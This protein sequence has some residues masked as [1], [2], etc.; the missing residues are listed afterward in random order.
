MARETSPMI[1]SLSVENMVREM[2]CRVTDSM[3]SERSISAPSGKRSQ[4]WA[5]KAWAASAMAG[6]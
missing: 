1:S 2:I 3:S 6:A 4:R 5:R